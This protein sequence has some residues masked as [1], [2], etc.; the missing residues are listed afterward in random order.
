MV[1]SDR[2]CLMNDAKIEQLGS[3]TELYFRPRTMFAADFLGESNF[4]SVTV[5]D[6]RGDEVLLRGGDGATITVNNDE[7]R[8]IANGDAVKVMVRP[9]MLRL[10]AL[11]DEAQN[12]LDGH[13]DEVI[14][15]GGV[16]KHYV[17][18]KDGTMVVATG[19]T[20][21]PVEG[22]EKNAPIR[23][24]WNKENAVVLPGEGA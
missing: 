20:R 15:V 21:G 8:P 24:G 11:E 12:I 2:I 4:L 14:L 19:L 3:P 23:L 13:L 7:S 16:T 22:L 5:E 6:I 10:I 17:R 1:M 9:E 18:L